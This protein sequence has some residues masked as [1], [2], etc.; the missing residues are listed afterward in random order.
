MKR[1][2]IILLLL[3]LANTCSAEAPKIVDPDKPAI[4][5]Y[6]Y[7]LECIDGKDFTI[8][9][10]IAYDGGSRYG[11]DE[12]INGMDF[13][14]VRVDLRYIGITCPPPLIDHT[15]IG[16]GYHSFKWK[17]PDM[18]GKGKIGIH[19]SDTDQNSDGV[20]MQYNDS[21]VIPTGHEVGTLAEVNLANSFDIPDHRSPFGPPG[22]PLV[23]RYGWM[24][25]VEDGVPSPDVV[26]TVCD[27]NPPEE[28][29]VCIDLS[30]F[31]VEEPLPFDQSMY[32]VIEGGIY[33]GCYEYS[34]QLYGLSGRG[35]INVTIADADGNVIEIPMGE[36][37]YSFAGGELLPEPTLIATSGGVEIAVGDSFNVTRTDDIV[38]N[39]TMVNNTIVHEQNA[40]A[41]SG[42]AGTFVVLAL[43]GAYLYRRE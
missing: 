43:L 25:N 18:R 13:F 41:T 22:S 31:G 21:I 26:V 28:I 35:N 36:Y 1:I 14:Y 16:D 3:I 6:G 30:D 17:I 11:F 33:D 20:E 34:G 15:D 10:V 5:N 23:V 38:M 24:S 29:T 37:E 19:A 7:T 2:V 9:E 32:I 42:F 4:V 8:I 27:D 39:E 40:P 12:D